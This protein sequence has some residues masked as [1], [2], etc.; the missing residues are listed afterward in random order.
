MDL[1]FVKVHKHAKKEFDQYSSILT[2]Q[3]VNNPYILL[4]ISFDVFFDHFAMY[5]RL[6]VSGTLSE[7]YPKKLMKIILKFTTRTSGV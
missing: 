2:S 5:S 3:L 7:I 1:D 4:L 6:M